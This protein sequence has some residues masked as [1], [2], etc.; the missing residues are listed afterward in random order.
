[1]KANTAMVSDLVKTL[2]NRFDKTTLTVE[3]PKAFKMMQGT[4]A[5]FEMVTT[6]TLQPCILHYKH[7]IVT[8]SIAYIFWNSEYD[9]QYLA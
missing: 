1:M 9:E 5:K 8:Y 7:N 4:D 6:S 3:I 2:T